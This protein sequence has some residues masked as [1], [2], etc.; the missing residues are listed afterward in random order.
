MQTLQSWTSFTHTHTHTH[1]HFLCCF[2]PNSDPITVLRHRDEQLL[3]HQPPQKLATSCHG[4]TSVYES[5]VKERRPRRGNAKGE[6]GGP[7]THQRG[8]AILQSPE[9]WGGKHVDNNHTHSAETQMHTFMLLP[10]GTRPSECSVF[11]IIFRLVTLLP[12]RLPGKKS[13][14]LNSPSTPS[15]TT[16]VTS[17]SHLSVT[18]STGIWKHIRRNRLFFMHALCK[19]TICSPDRLLI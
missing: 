13:L 10:I 2:L 16:S 11:V 8:G 9:S 7:H 3:F 1:T 4:A 5:H 18:G 15:L 17:L 6:R 14:L 19:R 12:L